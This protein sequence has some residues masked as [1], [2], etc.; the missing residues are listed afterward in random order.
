[1]N[2]LRKN[3]LSLQQE[4]FQLVQQTGYSSKNKKNFKKIVYL[5]FCRGLVCLDQL[6]Q[7]ERLTGNVFNIEKYQRSDLICDMEKPL[8][9]IRLHQYYLKYNFDNIN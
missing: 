7:K 3:Y 8:N 9:I 1:M 6:E 4:I 2:H 5:V